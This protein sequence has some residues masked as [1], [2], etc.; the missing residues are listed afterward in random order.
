MVAFYEPVSDTLLCAA[1]RCLDVVSLQA[2]MVRQEDPGARVVSSP[3]MNRA[4]HPPACC[5]SPPNPPALCTRLVDAVPM[6]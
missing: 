1:P 3:N 2:A 6:P 4:P 5:H